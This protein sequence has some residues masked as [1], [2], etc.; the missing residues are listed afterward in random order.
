MNNLS[1]FME[2]PLFKN[3]SAAELNELLP[4]II[5]RQEDYQKG[6][7]V[8]DQGSSIHEIGIIESGELIGR[9]YDLMGH[10]SVIA[11]MGRG[12]IFGESY[13]YLTNST[14]F[15]S[16]AAVKN[17]HVIFLD[18]TAMKEVNNSILNTNYISIIAKKNVAL[19]RKMNCV[20]P[21]SIRERLMAYLETERNIHQSNS[22]DIDF[23]RQEL[24]DYLLVDRSSLSHEL[25]LMQKEGLITFKKNHFKINQV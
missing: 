10:A 18:A 3:L 16:V 5:S 8:F 22:F 19:T 1:F 20:T 4:R 12:D 14:L 2:L 7:T 13:A 11:R 9:N 23:N 21:K 17:S 6:E 15:V 24:A 25:S